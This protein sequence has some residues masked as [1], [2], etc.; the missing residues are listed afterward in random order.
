MAR[1]RDARGAGVIDLA[2]GR[3]ARGAGVVDLERGNRQVYMD[4]R[5][6]PPA[7]GRGW[8]GVS[9]YSLTMLHRKT[10]IEAS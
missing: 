5:L 7:M 6:V 8:I 3:D 2:K 10:L 4:G 9:F 1:G